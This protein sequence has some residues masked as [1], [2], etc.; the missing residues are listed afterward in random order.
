MNIRRAESVLELPKKRMAA[1]A[2][3]LNAEHE[4]LI[5]KPTYRAEWLVPG[6]IVEAD[7]SPRTAC[8]REVREEIGIDVTLGQILCLDYGSADVGRTE[9]LHFIFFGGRLNAH[10]VAQIRLSPEEIA[11]SRFVS[12]A[13][14]NEKL[15]PRL[16]KR[17]RLALKALEENRTIYSENG[18]A[19]L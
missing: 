4:I 2:L 18:V 16:A 17:I 3:L 8:I 6:G 14:A 12:P 7:E 11:D 19:L 13:A 10:M 1:G 15:A 9:S 5:V